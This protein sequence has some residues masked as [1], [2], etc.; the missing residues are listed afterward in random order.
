MRILV[1]G[2]AGYI[3]SHV[4]RALSAAGLDTVVI[5]DLSTGH[6]AAVA[7]AVPARGPAGRSAVPLIVGDIA[8]PAALDAALA[9]GPIDGVVH[10]AAA[11]LVGDSMVRPAR[12]F[13]NNVV[14]TF[15]LIENL[16][17]RGVRRFVLSSTAATYG[18]PV[19]GGPIRE[20]DPT[21]PTNV[22]GETKLMIERALDWHARLSGLSAISL[23]YFN[24]A[25]AHPGGGIG[26]DHLRETHLIP[27]VMQVALGQRPELTVMG[28]DYPTPDGTCLRDYIHVA[29]L[30]EAHRLALEA[31]TAEGTAA[32]ARLRIY[33][34]GAERALSVL[35]V[36]AAARQVTG[37]PIPA[38]DGPRR[39]GD[40]ATLL[41][42]SARIRADLGWRPALSGLETILSTAW[43]WHREHPSGYAGRRA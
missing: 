24:A 19:G 10:M 37:R 32:P 3:G 18:D 35:E 22:Y 43:D 8:D 33:N 16:L 23:R 27:L 36:L 30:A 2:G 41:A 7:A 17:E 39:A 38:A 20:D 15:R 28:R 11:S 6:E 14:R 25:G 26:E 31:L 4:V 40:P 5:D 13:E 34:L 9:G 29:D 42:S 21:R 12:Y 1:T